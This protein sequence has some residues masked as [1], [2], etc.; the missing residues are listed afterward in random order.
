MTYKSWFDD[1]A[2]KHKVLT[3]KLISKGLS[4]D[5]IIKYFRFENMVEKENDF[6]ELYKTQ[7]KCHDMETLNCYLC[8]CPNF[9]FTSKP[10]KQENKII[11]SSCSINSKNGAIFEHENNIHQDCSNC[12][13]PHNENYMKEQFS[14]NWKETMKECPT[15]T[16]HD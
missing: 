10:K 11:H 13:V 2:D 15:D 12:Q 9:R 1:F 3:K 7:T 16:L 4:K 14:N 8:A 6:C 5:E